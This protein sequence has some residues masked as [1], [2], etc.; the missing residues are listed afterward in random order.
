MEATLLEKTEHFQLA[1]TNIKLHRL[2]SIKKYF[3]ELFVVREMQKLV[4]FLKRI[5]FKDN[6]NLIKYYSALSILNNCIQKNQFARNDSGHVQQRFIKL[7]YKVLKYA[8]RSIFKQFLH[9]PHHLFSRTDSL[10][11]NPVKPI[12]FKYVF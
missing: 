2:Q 1:V 6:L 8:E 3:S 11:M 10:L 7:I 4:K 9:F 5:R 12:S